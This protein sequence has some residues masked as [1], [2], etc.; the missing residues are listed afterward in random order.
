MDESAHGVAMHWFSDNL[1]LAYPV[2]GFQPATCLSQL[3][4]EVSYL[5][6]AFI[7]AGLLGRG[8]VARGEFFADQTFIY[9]P[10]LERAVVLEHS[11]AIYPR[12]VIDERTCR[13]AIDALT[14]DD[15]SGLGSMW[16]KWLAVD[17]KGVVFIDYL[18]VAYD[19]PAGYGV[20]I[21]ALVERH[22]ELIETNLYKYD[23]VEP[24]EEKYRWLAGYHNY[25]VDALVASGE[26]DRA[27][28]VVASRVA[29]GF[30]SF[31][32]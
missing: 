19:D 1:S 9:G 17:D 7:E 25:A 14:V 13:V 11:R 6:G 5:Q 3:I 10:A 2:D 20:D 22:K 26:A 24:V 12:C 30:A 18:R 31:G 8:A 32:N 15:S 21:N 29:S 4:A 28:P 27:E 16:R 23:G